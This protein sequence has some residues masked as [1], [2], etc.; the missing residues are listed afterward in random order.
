MC[1]IAGLF[2]VSNPK[3]VDP[4]RVRAMTDVLAHR[5]PDGS[6]VWTA[7][8]VGLGHR[9]LSIID[10]ATGD[11][12][13]RSADGK[14]A[15]SYN[16]EIYNFREVRAQLEPLGHVFRTESDTEV[17]LAAWRQWGPDCLARF[18]GMFAFALY[19]GDRDSLF[20]A[21]DRLG[22][23]PLYWTTLSD[24]SLVFASELKGLLAHP[25]MRRAPS[26][27]AV[28]D[29]LALGYVP[30]DNC[31]VDGV[32]K[33][34]A[35]HHLLVRRGRVVPKPVQWW[36]VDF[37]NPS[38]ASVAT[39]EEELVERLRE[40]VRSRMV[41]DVPLGAFLSGGVDSSAV[42]ALMAEASRSAVQTC[43]IGFTEADHD[44]SK[45]AALVAE[46][47][48]TSHRSRIVAADDFGLIDTLADAF[49]EP[50]ADASAL[51]TY[52]VSELARE[53]VKV[54]LSGDGADE[55][56]AGYRRYRMFAA[57]E[58]VRGL[59]PGPAR[60]LLGAV[61]DLYPKLDWAPRFLRAKTTLQA[62]RQEGGQAYAGAVGVTPPG[63]RSSLYTALFKRFL[64]GYR[65]EERYVKAMAGAPA[66]DA[67]S[68][69]QYADLKIW[70]PGDILTKV[71]RTSMAVGLEAREPL[72][73]HRLVE[74][75]ARLPARMRLRG[76]SGKWL[77][78][79]ALGRYLPD[80]LLNRTK[81]GFVTP[82]SAWFRGPLAAE[83]ASIAH[84]PALIELGW[85]DSAAVA[86]LAAAHRSGREEH[87]RLLW[88]LL[89]LDK[90][91]QRLFGFG[92]GVRKAG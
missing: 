42:V 16:G 24:D 21:R 87:G 83:A 15:L 38:S 3:P 63:I 33:L 75:A 88:Q 48:A 84:S 58:R 73:D 9:R 43:S 55:A 56:F 18:N 47:F 70:L 82:I 85:F 6:G 7:P 4:K 31:M 19:D 90:S 44:E 79:R 28:D 35:G 77:M 26:R 51:A 25:L 71:D 39:L 86:R 92:A 64:G 27:S 59:L 49:D 20:L 52:R 8:G 57:E 5:G 74:F 41:A 34:A 69:A 14:L 65:G 37:S 12:P 22:V 81:M 2:Y 29:Y 40:A 30:D 17:I 60:G 62:I 50:F 23:K 89:M 91:L 32:R 1:G 36:D 66:G 46:R 78:K 54:A 67:L 61:G 53:T 76:G 80:Q 11:Q 13:M 68:R 10:L 72:L 45:W